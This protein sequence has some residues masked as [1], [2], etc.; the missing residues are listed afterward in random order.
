MSLV[1]ASCVYVN[2]SKNSGS[3]CVAAGWLWGGDVGADVLAGACGWCG[4]GCGVCDSVVS[5]CWIGGV[6]AG[7]A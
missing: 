3:R 5:V 4:D 1:L 7:L 6:S 2:W